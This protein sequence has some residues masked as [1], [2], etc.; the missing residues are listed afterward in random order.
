M[1]ARREKELGL[2]TRML[3]YAC[4]RRHGKHEG[5]CPEC[6]AL[7]V[8]VEQRLLRCPYGDTKPTCRRCPV[9]CYRPAERAHIRA[10][11]RYAGPR[12]LCSGSF[13][14]FRHLL[15]DS[16]RRH[17]PRPKST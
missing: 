14:A 16:F 1:V 6:A 5:L 13:A 3:R 2:V 4:A 11:M 12:L 7:L 9:H 17:P 15:H 10:I 8:Y